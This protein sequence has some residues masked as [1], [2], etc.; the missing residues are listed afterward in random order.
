MA[1]PLTIVQARVAL[2]DP[3]A[4]TDSADVLSVL[5]AIFDTLVR[6]GAGG[7]W[8]PALATSWEIGGDA[9]TFEFRLRA[10]VTFH[11]GD[12]MDAEAVRY[13][14]A[15]M[16]R[17][18]MG[19]TLGA[20][21]VY[22]QYL[23]GSAFEVLAADRLRVTL[24]EPMADLFDILARGHIVSPRAIE[25]A[26][27]DLA[28]RMVGT[29]P[30]RLT[31][32][33]E[34]EF[35]EAAATA[36]DHFDGRPTARALRWQAVTGVS[37]RARMLADGAARVATRLDLS[38]TAALSTHANLTFSRSL[39]PIAIVYL[40]NAAKG[41]MRDARVRRALNLGVDRTALVE[42]VLGGLGQPLHGFISPAHIG[43][44]PANVAAGR[45][46]FDRPQARALL[47]EAGF[48]AGLTLIAD[49]PERLPDEAA[50]L[51]AEVARQLAAIG[52]HLEIR[53]EPDRTRY[54]NRVRLKDI[55]DLCLFDSSPMSAFRVLF[56]KIDAR[57]RGAWWQG[58]SEPRVEALLDRAR[59][60]VDDDARA[61]L[62]RQCYRLLQ[63]D[64]PWLY[65]Y[66]HHRITGLAGRHPGW[67]QG[68]D[69]VLDVR[70][71]PR[72][73]C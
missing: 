2:D 46:P 47:A 59:R 44:D 33:V 19:A 38:T 55:G 8:Q 49:R 58:Y 60:T 54:A 45:M 31:R 17:P 64:P 11:N 24:V 3:H 37:T 40:F 66:N 56:E 25:A 1:G 39:D 14:L 57:P 12:V 65:L 72:I 26:G 63:D 34:G 22:A 15:R 30:Y 32:W 53:V 23:S 42:R 61:A 9:R 52:I 4:C 27:D 67:Q 20:P 48:G 36:A 21:G 50:T 18:D 6:R 28:A 69:G 29:G 13:S 68:V 35:M 71:L 51:T 41:P 70:A 43:A 5:S 62:Y 16:A 7:S 10:G 73:A